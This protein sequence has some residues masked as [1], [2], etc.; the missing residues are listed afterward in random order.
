MGGRPICNL[1]FADDIVL[2]GSST[3]EPQELTNRL[4]DRATAYGMEVSTEKSNIMTIGTNIIN[5]DISMNR[6][7][8]EEV[9]NFKYMGATLCKDGTCSAK[10]R[11]RIAL[12]MTAVARLSRIWR[13]NTTSFAS[14]FKPYKSLVISILLYDCET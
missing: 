4:V 12:V 3:G 10:V 9:T 2:M 13:C 7:K 8:L 11:I 6:Q 5:A 1:R 14:N